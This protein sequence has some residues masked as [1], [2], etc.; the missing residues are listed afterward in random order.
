[1][2]ERDYFIKFDDEEIHK[3]IMDLSPVQM[4]IFE[5]EIKL[6]K[7]GRHALFIA[8]S[9]CAICGRGRV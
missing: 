7:T 6:G 1:M 9:F 2:E 5:E 3:M 8:K 4:K